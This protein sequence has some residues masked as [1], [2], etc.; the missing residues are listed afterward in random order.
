MLSDQ[1]LFMH[2]FVVCVAFYSGCAEVILDG[3]SIFFFCIVVASIVMVWRKDDISMRSKFTADGCVQHTGSHE[4]MAH[5]NGNQFC[6]SSVLLGHKLLCN[7]AIE[8]NVDLNASE[9][10]GYKQWY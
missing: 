2:D 5:D 8:A 10:V 7:R 3:G 4:T 9:K 1:D 6:T